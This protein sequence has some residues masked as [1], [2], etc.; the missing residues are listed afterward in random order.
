MKELSIVWYFFAGFYFGTN[1]L[2]KIYVLHKKYNVVYY[3]ILNFNYENLS[4]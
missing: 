1:I 4:M 3:I 2:L